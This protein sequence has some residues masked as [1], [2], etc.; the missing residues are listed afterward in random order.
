[1]PSVRFLFR[2]WIAAGARTSGWILH[3]K[4]LLEGMWVIPRT[5]IISRDFA[6]LAERVVGI[7]RSERDLNPVGYCRDKM[8]TL[9]RSGFYSHC[10]VADW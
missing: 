3:L 9:L 4:D 8:N 7:S 10:E 5:E 1:M 2:E 6:G